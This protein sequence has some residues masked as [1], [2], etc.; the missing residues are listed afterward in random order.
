MFTVML[1]KINLK[2]EVRSQKLMK[3]SQKLKVDSQKV[4]VR[5]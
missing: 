3:K 1:E 5:S 2:S 4:E